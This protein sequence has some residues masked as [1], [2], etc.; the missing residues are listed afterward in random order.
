MQNARSL[1]Q[2][3][4]PAASITRTAVCRQKLASKAEEKSLTL[5]FEKF[6][7]SIFL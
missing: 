3:D 7:T 2:S 4:P 6:S 1:I 5:F